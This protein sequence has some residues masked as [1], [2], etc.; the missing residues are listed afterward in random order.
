MSGALEQPTT[1]GRTRNQLE[2]YEHEWNHESPW[3]YTVIR[4]SIAAVHHY[5]SWLRMIPPITQLSASKLQPILDTKIRPMRTWQMKQPIM[6]IGVEDFGTPELPESLG[7]GNA[8]CQCSRPWLL[9][10]NNKNPLYTWFDWTVYNTFGLWKDS[11]NHSSAWRLR[12]RKQPIFTLSIR[13]LN[14]LHIHLP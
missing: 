13:W 12:S 8:D 9:W 2:K 6:L 14:S 11:K 7:K 3:K 4:L 1:E 10:L 5:R